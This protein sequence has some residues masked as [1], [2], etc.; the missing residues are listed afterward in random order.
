MKNLRTYAVCVSLSLMSLVSF[1]QNQKAPPLNEPDLNRPRLFDN[2]PNR[3]PVD[4][5]MISSLFNSNVGEQVDLGVAD[6]NSQQTMHVDGEV[7]S[8]VSR[9]NGKIEVVIVR[10]SNYEGANLSLTKMTN[11]DNTVSYRCRILSFKHGDLL[12]LQKAPEGY[13]LVKRNFYDL[14]NE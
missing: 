5:N 6:K 9:E 13:V 4:I 11:D 3:I 2:L 10:S 12:E 1:A 8:K 7:I 14:V